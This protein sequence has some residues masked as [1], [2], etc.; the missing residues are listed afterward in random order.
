[1]REGS[2]MTEAVSG[3]ASGWRVQRDQDGLKGKRVRNHGDGR[4]WPPGGPF[5]RSGVLMKRNA[6]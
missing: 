5:E 4:H 2:E 1:M 6:N 3:R